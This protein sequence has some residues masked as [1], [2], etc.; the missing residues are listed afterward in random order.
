MVGRNLDRYLVYRITVETCQVCHDA[1]SKSLKLKYIEA[2]VFRYPFI[3]SYRTLGKSEQ[4]MFTFINRTLGKSEQG[5]FTFI[6]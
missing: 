2:L 5:M 6:N 3:S 1:H 4:G